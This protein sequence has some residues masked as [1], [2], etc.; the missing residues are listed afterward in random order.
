MH[1]TVLLLVLTDDP[2]DPYV[3]EHLLTRAAMRFRDPFIIWIGLTM[4]EAHFHMLFSS[5]MIAL[6]K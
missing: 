6:E 3:H 1:K 5:G 2:N 4:N